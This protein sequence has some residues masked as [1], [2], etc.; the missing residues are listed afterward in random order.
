MNSTLT[1]TSSPFEGGANVSLSGSLVSMNALDL[2]SELHK[3]INKRQKLV[4]DI[5]NVTDIDLTG[6]NTLMFTKVK[7]SL[8]YSD[9]VIVVS[10]GHPIMKLL[11]LT[12]SEGQ[13]KIQ[14]PLLT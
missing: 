12:R 5:T 14:K 8:K 4:V 6:L 13:F 2:K 7:C 1:V 3:H 11:R 9:M 10:D